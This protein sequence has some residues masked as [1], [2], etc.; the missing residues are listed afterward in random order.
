MVVLEYTTTE[1]ETGTVEVNGMA[2]DGD[3]TLYKGYE[4]ACDDIRAKIL[5]DLG[6]VCP[7]F[8][9]LRGQAG[10]DAFR[11]IRN[12]QTLPQ[13]AELEEAWAGIVATFHSRV[14]STRIPLEIFPDAADFFAAY[15]KPA[16]IVTNA[17][18]VNLF[19]R[20][21]ANPPLHKW[22]SSRFT[23]VVTACRVD[24]RIKPDPAMLNYA[25]KRMGLPK[26]GWV[27]DGLPDA[28]AGHAAG[29]EV[30]LSLSRG[31][32]AT[33]MA[34]IAAV[35]G[36]KILK[37]FSALRPLFPSSSSRRLPLE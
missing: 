5:A 28:L 35:P 32:T 37:D 13:Q 20:F 18:R 19:Q 6:F 31:R 3:S 25:K 30:N 8:E 22:V 27:G 9:A 34:A 23:E 1:G 26:M 4:E 33:E 14:D 16:A 36:V 12:A 10:P 29:V 24:G 11:I 17:Q 2:V 21:E 7:D 15:R